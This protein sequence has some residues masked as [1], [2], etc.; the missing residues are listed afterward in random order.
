MRTFGAWRGLEMFS[1]LSH[2]QI[3]NQHFG[4]KAHNLGDGAVGMYLPPRERRDVPS[5]DG[6]LI[7]ELRD[8]KL[9]EQGL[10]CMHVILYACE[11]AC[12]CA[13]AWSIY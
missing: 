10:Y 7:E 2:I 13:C 11:C 6:G 1:V 9:T 4:T 8:S 3:V 12:A 5:A